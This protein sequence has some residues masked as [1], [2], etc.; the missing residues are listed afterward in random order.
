MQRQ[1]ET[2]VALLK[3]IKRNSDSSLMESMFLS[4]DT[5][6]LKDFKFFPLKLTTFKI[7]C[8]LEDPLNNAVAICLFHSH[9]NEEAWILF[10]VVQS[11]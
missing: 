5:E 4:F 9:H 8:V 3:K 10:G 6:R 11:G 7:H 1:L 2:F